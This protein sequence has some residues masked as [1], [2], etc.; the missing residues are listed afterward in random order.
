MSRKKALKR[1]RELFRILSISE[2]RRAL[3]A[4]PTSSRNKVHPIKLQDALAA[5]RKFSEILQGDKSFEPDAPGVSE[6]ETLE[7]DRGG[8]NWSLTA[9]VRAMCVPA[10]A[11]KVVANKC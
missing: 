4:D 8:R 6:D 3:K 10:L 7:G 9:R 11:W 5:I 1:I 2:A